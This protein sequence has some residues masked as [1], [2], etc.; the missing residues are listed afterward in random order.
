MGVAEVDK[1]LEKV[2]TKVDEKVK[3]RED[4]SWGDEDSKVKIYVEFPDGYLK[5]AKI[6]AKFEDLNFQILLT[7]E[8]RETQGVTNGAHPLAN[9]IVPESC[10]YRINSAK[11][12]LTITL[13]KKD[14]KEPWSNLKK[15]VISQHT[16]WN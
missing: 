3:W 15:K 2:E 9:T 13:K 12:R 5:D 11:T 7:A 4:Y 8:G 6:E 1:W 14:D 10:S 16:G